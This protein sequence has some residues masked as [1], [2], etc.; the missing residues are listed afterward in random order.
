VKL[1]LVVLR[2]SVT[3]LEQGTTFTIRQTETVD[4]S[5]DA[6]LV[7]VSSREGT[8]IVPMTNVKYAV[9]ADSVKAKGK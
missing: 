9:P 3:A 2:D 4:V 8:I 5:L 1:K 6:G 7:T